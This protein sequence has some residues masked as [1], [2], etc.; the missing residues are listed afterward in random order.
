MATEYP[1]SEFTGIDMCPVF[2]TDIRPPNVKFQYG[3]VMERL[4]FDDNTFD[5]INMRFF[6]LALKK[7]DW[8][9]V[10]PELHRI[11][12]PGGVLQSLESSMLE[13]GTDFIRHAGKMC[14][15]LLSMVRCFLFCPLFLPLFRRSQRYN[16]R[17]RA[18]TIHCQ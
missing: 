1:E 5:L 15:C 4:P 7:E 2:P 12:K 14:K 10:L 17:P 11:L 16:D 9:V 8:D 13:T 18:G 3:N 6:I